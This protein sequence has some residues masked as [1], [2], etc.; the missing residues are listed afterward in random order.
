MN[1]Y[2][3]QLIANQVARFLSLTT[4]PIVEIKPVRRGLAR[5]KTRKITIPDWVLSKKCRRQAYQKYYIAHEV[6]HFHTGL[7]HN[8]GFKR[9]EADVLNQLFAITIRRDN[10]RPWPWRPPS[11]HRIYPTKLL[12]RDTG[13]VLWE[14]SHEPE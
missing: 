3:L 2:E 11:D 12:D 5:P 8:S 10:R 7:K 6:T 4:T 1:Q 13:E 9:V 14:G